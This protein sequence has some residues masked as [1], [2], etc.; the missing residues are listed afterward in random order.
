L[1]VRQGELRMSL[2]GMSFLQRLESFELRGKQ[3]VLR[4]RR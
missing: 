3:M 4:G 2:L 1:I